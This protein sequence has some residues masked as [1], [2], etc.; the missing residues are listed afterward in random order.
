VPIADLYLKSASTRSPLRVGLLLD[1]LTLPRAFQQ[2]VED[3]RNSNFASIELVVLHQSPEVPP[4]NR[5]PF[6]MRVWRI[7]R[8]KRRRRGLLYWWYANYDRRRNR[9]VPDPFEPCDIGGH[10]SSVPRL[11]V[12]PDVKGFTHRFPPA[13]IEAIRAHNLDVL[14]RFGFNILRGDVLQSARYGIWSFHH[15]D[16]DFYRGGPALF[17]ELVERSQLS[18]VMLQV[19]EEALDAGLVLC[20]SLFASEPG[21]SLVRNQ[22]GP[23]IGSTHMVIRKLH[24]LHQDGW[25]VVR[26]NGYPSRPYQGKRKLYRSPTNT[27]MVRWLVPSLAVKALKRPF[28]RPKVYHWRIGIRRKDASVA[29]ALHEAAAR[30]EFSGFRWL[31]S[32][33][34]HFWADPFL[35]DHDQG[36]WLF[37][38]D[39]SYRVDRGVI[40]VGRLDD[41]GISEVRTCLDLPFHLSYPCVFK[42][43]GEIFMIPETS[44]ANSV[45]LYRAQ[46]FPYEW[47]LEKVLCH[48]KAV[49]TTPWFD[50]A[51]WW[52]FTTLEEPTGHAVMSMLYSADDLTGDWTLHPSSPFCTDVRYARNAGAILTIDGR[53]FR[54]S[55]DCSRNYGGSLTLN[56]IVELNPER[57]REQAVVDI[58]PDSTLRFVGGHT[59]NTS[60]AFEVTDAVR[61]EPASQYR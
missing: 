60:D 15:G 13:A 48:A 47:K 3:I 56:E 20:K 2:V 5:V 9:L 17:W 8:D 19:L 37:F 23:Y 57:Y 18:G 45:Q 55:Q 6:P 28:R 36:T 26:A 42:H 50:G 32:P 7:L 4:P 61:Y 40:G 27:E 41:R 39:Y 16:N 11:T 12:A 44:D 43:A 33:R 29:S 1:G 21:L 30:R 24:E 31:E 25:E 22:W 49:D 38:E 58:F 46:R 54:P 59:Y 51:R 10:L 52:F 35:L 53:R 34:G 14:L